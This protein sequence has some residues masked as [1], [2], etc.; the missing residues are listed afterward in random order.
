MRRFTSAVI[1]ALFFLPAGVALAQTCPT[2]VVVQTAGS[3]P[4]CSG[5]PVTLDTGSGWAS[6]L[7]S[8]GATTRTMSDSPSV[9]TNY[10][11][12]TTDASG[13]QATSQPY[14][15]D[16]TYAAAPPTITISSSCSNGGSAHIDSNPPGWSG[17]WSATN[18]TI[19]R[20]DGQSAD[21]TTTGTDPVPGTW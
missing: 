3:N 15:V 14:H 5:V 9:A 21:F 20:Q 13:C 2:P 10:F 6:Y 11:V 4:T 8:N 16:V 12:T 18:A 1:L 19:T 17:T 7:W